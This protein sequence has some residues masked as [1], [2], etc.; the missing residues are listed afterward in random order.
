[1]EN[2]TELC[3]AGLELDR[4]SQ[5]KKKLRDAQQWAKGNKFYIRSIGKQVIYMA[6]KSDKVTESKRQIASDI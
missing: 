6:S 5:Y 4:G 2:I 3:P 1:M